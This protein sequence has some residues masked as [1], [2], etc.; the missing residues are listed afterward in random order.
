M[1]FGVVSEGVPAIEN[2]LSQLWDCAH[3][4]SNQKECRPRFMPRQKVEQGWGHGGIWSVVKRQRYAGI[5][6]GMLNG[7]AE[8][9]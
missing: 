2:L 5:V 7:G 1:R 3:M 4:P 8:K 6:A 9:L